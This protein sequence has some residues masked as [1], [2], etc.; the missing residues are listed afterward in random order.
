MARLG[1]RLAGMMIAVT[2]FNPMGVE[3]TDCSTKQGGLRREAQQQDE[4]NE[5]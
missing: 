5:V 3:E 1:D 2:Y 4:G